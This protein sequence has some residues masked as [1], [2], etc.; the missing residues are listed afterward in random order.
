M[1][2]TALEFEMSETLAFE[3]Q[4]ETFVALL[5]GGLY[6]P[7]L[8]MLL[9]ADLHLEKG[10][11]FAMRGQF[12]PPYDSHDS[13]KQLA[14]DIGALD[15]GHVV[16]LGDSFHDVG[17]PARLPQDCRET[18][19]DLMTNRKWSWICGNHDPQLDGLVGGDVLDTMVLEGGTGGIG[20]THEPGSLIAPDEGNDDETEAAPGLELSGH[21][22][23]VA[24]L[25]SR[26]RGRTMRR[27]SFVITRNRII[28]PAYGSYTGG[29][30]VRE[31]A[32]EPFLH[33]GA[34]LAV[35]GRQTICLFDAAQGLSNHRRSA[36][37]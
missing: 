32:F 11:A 7:R 6:L 18:L 20:L 19:S 37:L 17:G 15:P 34:R 10:S 16:C 35:I 27:K 4:G 26:Q 36:R 23:P 2:E 14:S 12:I 25:A 29:L 22:H 9:L 8:E 21:L 5:S 3:Q 24:T 33:A 31:A 28:L 13:L 30:N 1:S